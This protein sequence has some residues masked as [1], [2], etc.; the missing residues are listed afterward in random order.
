M[1]ADMFDIQ[2][3]VTESG[4]PRR[5]I[6]F[7]VQQGLLPPPQGAGLAAFYTEDHL[8]RLR[9]IPILRQQGLRLDR[10]REQFSHMSTED[11]RQ[12]VSDAALRAVEKQLDP[13]TVPAS[14][15]AL[16]EMH[17]I[18]SLASNWGEQSFTHYSLPAGIV[19][20]VPDGMSQVDRQRLHLLLQAARKI[21]STR[22]GQYIVH[23]PEK[24]GDDPESPGGG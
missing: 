23:K 2:K 19:I 17:E 24:P 18:S 1:S 3:L 11:M 20:T 4:V 9:L 14:A 12:Q 22:N 21:Y 13:P 15:P 6:Y 8:L 10:I 7:Y 16:P 5:T